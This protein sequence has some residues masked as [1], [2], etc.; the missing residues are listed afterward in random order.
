MLFFGAKDGTEGGGSL[1]AFHQ[2]CNALILVNRR[3]LGKVRRLAVSEALFFGG[4]EGRL[5]EGCLTNFWELVMSKFDGVER[6]LFV[7][8]GKEGDILSES[9]KDLGFER[10]GSGYTGNLDLNIKLKD[11]E[12][13]QD[14]V[15]RV[16]S[17]LEVERKWTAPRW[18]FL[19]DRTEVP[20]DQSR[21]VTEQQGVDFDSTTKQEF[22][23]Y[24]RTIRFK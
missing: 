12:S 15:V 10:R 6:L 11:E 16:V 23:E 9:D 2:F 4:R 20:D 21:T 17:A 19:T 13:F 7:G 14:I 1:Y 22:Y 3:E 8:K 18:K 24:L 5:V